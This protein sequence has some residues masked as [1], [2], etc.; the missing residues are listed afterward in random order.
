MAIRFFV[1]EKTPFLQRL[2]ASKK[3]NTNLVPSSITFGKGL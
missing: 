1:L 2:G 3:I